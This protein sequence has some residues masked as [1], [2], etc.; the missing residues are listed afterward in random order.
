MS[1]APEAVLFDFDGTLADSYPA[2]TAS[3]NHI[4]SLYGLPALAVSEVK[5]FVGHGPENL[6]EHTVP[7]CQPQIDGRKY[8]EHHPSVMYELTHLFPGVRE[9][10]AALSAQG[11][12]L[13]VCSNKPRRF[14]TALLEHFG[15]AGLFT[16]VLGP[17]DVAAAK[18]APDMLLK[19]AELLALDRE[20]I[21]YVGDMRV[22]LRTARSAGVPV[23]LVPTGSDSREDLLAANP[24]RLIEQIA[25][26]PR[27]LG[28]PAAAS[29]D[30]S[31]GQD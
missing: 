16:V 19:A 3:V 2:I 17:E 12:R 18:P 27:W 14:T 30:G 26:I 4:R 20:R 9:A 22:D 24:D 31:H 1:F 13:G 28:L 29:G 15:V 25:D 11:L 7:G 6:L 8:R 21:L 5:P 23:W 10:L